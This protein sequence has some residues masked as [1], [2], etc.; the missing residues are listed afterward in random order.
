MGGGWG[1]EEEEEEEVMDASR[2]VLSNASSRVR[3]VSSSRSFFSRSSAHS[4]WISTWVEG[5]WVGG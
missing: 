3:M 5:G 1:R 2:R 4:F